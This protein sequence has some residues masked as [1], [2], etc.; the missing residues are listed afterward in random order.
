MNTKGNQR[1]QETK[2]RIKG[3]LFNLLKEGKDT[4]SVRSICETAQI[5]RTTFYGHYEDINALLQEMV[6]DLYRQIK[7]YLLPDKQPFDLK[8]FCKLFQL[9]KEEREFFLYYFSNIRQD[10][11][12]DQLVPELLLEKHILLEEQMGL[13]SE[14]EL[15]Y[16]QCFFAA[17]ATQM[18]IRWLKMGCIE[19][20]EEMGILMENNF[21]RFFQI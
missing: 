18:L 11:R 5:H 6:V 17:G 12:K 2:S 4:I 3:A 19:S 13:K 21:K 8:G 16:Q 15:M 9:A 14:E 7:E 20:P 10:L 1:Y